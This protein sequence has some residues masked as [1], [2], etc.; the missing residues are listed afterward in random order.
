MVRLFG[1][2]GKK[3]KGLEEGSRPF[4]FHQPWGGLIFA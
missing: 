2:Y 3:M 4:G 1:G